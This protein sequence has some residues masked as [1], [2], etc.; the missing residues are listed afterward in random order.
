[1][2]I[3]FEVCCGT[4]DDA[5][6]AAAGG[7]DRIELNSAL[8]LGGLTPSLGALQVVKA[9][10]GVPVVCM[11]RPREAG[12]CYSETEFAAMQADAKAL[13]AAGADGL[14]FGFLHPDGTVDEARTRCFVQLCGEKEAVFHRAFDVTPDRDAAIK[15]LIACG[16][17]RVL[18]SGGAVSAPAGKDE[19]RRLQQTYGEQIEILPGGGIRAEN[20]AQLAAYTG[21]TQV[22]GSARSVVADTST[23]NNPAIVFG[24]AIEGKTLPETEFKRTDPA[25]V[26]AVKNALK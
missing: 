11:V 4:A 6:Q 17:K 9:G 10:C 25:L 3:L 19:L 23:E 8:F 12:F 1:M 14:A 24:G 20:A 2:S 18:T 21:V 13:L 15:T 16:V 5:L 22:H 26:R 7:T